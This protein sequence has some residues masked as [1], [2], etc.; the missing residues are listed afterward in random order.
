MTKKIMTYSSSPNT[1]K[2]IDKLLKGGRDKEQSFG[3]GIMF[4]KVKFGDQE[5]YYENRSVQHFSMP[6]STGTPP[7]FLIDIN[8]YHHSNDLQA[9][10]NIEGQRILL[11]STEDFPHNT[12]GHQVIS[13]NESMDQNILDAKRERFGVWLEDPDRYASLGEL[14][15]SNAEAASEFARHTGTDN[16]QAQLV[17]IFSR[18]LGSPEHRLATEKPDAQAMEQEPPTNAI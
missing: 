11:I 4:A 12:T 13:L 15:A 18:L 3:I 14:E 1:L 10:Q 6:R 2:L 5:Y 16:S 7:I 8:D 17:G 9:L